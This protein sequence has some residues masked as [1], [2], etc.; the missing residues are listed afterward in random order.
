MAPVTN[1]LSVLGGEQAQ[2]CA[3]RHGC[4]RKGNGRNEVNRRFDCC[5]RAHSIAAVP[6]GV[7]SL[8]LAGRS[9]TFFQTGF[10]TGARVAKIAFLAVL[11]VMLGF[12][13]PP[14][15]RGRLS[16]E[17]VDQI[18]A[19]VTGA[20]AAALA[21]LPCK[22]GLRSKPKM[23]RWQDVDKCLSQ[24]ALR[25]SWDAVETQLRSVRPAG[26]SEDEFEAV[27]EVSLSKHALAYDQLFRVKNKE[28]LLPLT[29]SILKYLPP[30]SLKDLPV[31]DQSGKPIGTFAGTFLHEH[32]GG[33]TD[34][35]LTL[36]QF[37]DPQG[38][39]QAPAE[40]L[41]LDTYG[42]PWAQAAT[43]PGFRLPNSRPRSSF[44]K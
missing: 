44:E 27:I 20:Y 26:V 1:M 25:A 32:E 12:A 42:V 29:N 4:L 35:S 41:L 23:L 21:K 9:H 7:T 2:K 8:R 38:K 43:R 14:P 15:Q 39:I 30:D 6:V 5:S 11:T 19:A 37:A 13:A 22:V 36:F 40:R 28:A 24:A 18:D 3:G 10:V 17:V 33:M 16:Q 31:Y 34:A